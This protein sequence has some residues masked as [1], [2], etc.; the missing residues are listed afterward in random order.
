MDWPFYMAYRAFGI[1]SLFHRCEAVKQ[2]CVNEFDLLRV[3]MGGRPAK[4]CKIEACGELLETG[5][6]A[7]HPFPGEQIQTVGSAIFERER[8]MIGG[9]RR[10]AVHCRGGTAATGADARGLVRSL[11]ADGAEVYNNTSQ[12]LE[13]IG[14]AATGTWLR[15]RG[16]SSCAARG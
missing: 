6:F 16:G 11:L 9:A 10:L 13:A 5:A 14:V 1:M 8:R 3:E 4:G 12:T 15:W 2:P 7:F